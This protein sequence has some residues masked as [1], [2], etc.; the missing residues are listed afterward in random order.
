VKIKQRESVTSTN[1]WAR[2]YAVEGGALPCAFLAQEQTAGRG[3]RE[4]TWDSPVGWTYLSIAFPPVAD[5]LTKLPLEVAEAVCNLL[6]EIYSESDEF[7]VKPPNDVLYRDEKKVAG[8]LV[9]QFK[10]VV[11]VG[12]GVDYPPDELVDSLIVGVTELF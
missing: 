7:S 4:N 10:D 6:N 2:E 9:E 5:P 3:R 1:D 12:I 8:I 11:I